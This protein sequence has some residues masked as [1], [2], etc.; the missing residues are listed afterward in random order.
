M[1][2][3][4]NRGIVRGSITSITIRKTKD[5]SKPYGDIKVFC[6]SKE[7]GDLTVRVKFWGKELP[8]LQEAIKEC[9][10]GKYWFD[11]DMAI[12]EQRGE[13]VLIFNAYEFKP[14]VPAKDDEARATFIIEG[15]VKANFET[16]ELHYVKKHSI[17]PKDFTFK[18]PEIEAAW[19]VDIDDH[20][21]V[22]GH[23]KDIM[24]KYGGSGEIEPIIEKVRIKNKKAP[25]D[26]F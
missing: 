5:N 4:F 18:F 22:A 21:T 15:I 8:A 3:D 12:L 9:P 16:F 14:W 7:Y 25:S 19:G 13:E 20:V 11:G 1:A 10:A 17:Y 2:N 6:S 23:I 24:Q 26:P